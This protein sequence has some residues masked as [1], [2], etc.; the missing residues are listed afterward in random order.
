MFIGIDDTDSPAGMCTT[1]LGAVL[2]RRLKSAGLTIRETRL[3]RL[4]PNA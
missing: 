2:V 4:N 1:Y 3:V